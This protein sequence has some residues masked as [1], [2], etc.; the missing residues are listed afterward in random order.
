[1]GSADYR[2]AQAINIAF[3]TIPPSVFELNALDE[4]DQVHAVGWDSDL[5]NRAFCLKVCCGQSV[6]RGSK[7]VERPQHTLRVFCGRSYP[8]V[9][10]PCRS[11]QAMGCHRIS[12]DDEKLN[13]FFDEG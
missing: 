2:D 9:E 3:G 6:P 5:I 8:K 10:I 11:G 13:A 7:Y 1:V 4:G 12:T